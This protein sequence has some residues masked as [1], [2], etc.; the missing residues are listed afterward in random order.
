MSDDRDLVWRPIELGD[1]ANWSRSAAGTADEMRYYGGVHPGWRGRGIG[2]R[3]LDRAEAAA[4]PLHRERYPDL[5]LSL[6]GSCLAGNAAAAALYA[7]HGYQP[8]RWFHAMTRDLSAACLRPASLP[9]S[10]SSATRR[11]GRRTPG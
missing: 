6:H 3:L 8:V 10:T 9:G 7:A 1:V 2:G 11:R 4:V 5:P